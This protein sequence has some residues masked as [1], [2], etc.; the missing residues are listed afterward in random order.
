MSAETKLGLGSALAT[1]GALGWVLS[2]L[3]GWPTA[4]HFWGFLFLFLVGMLA[5]VGAT[6]AVTGLIERRHGDWQGRS[7]ENVSE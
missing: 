4:S 3:L 5:G 1:L 7:S 6:L 2:L